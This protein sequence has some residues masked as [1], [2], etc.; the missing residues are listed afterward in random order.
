MGSDPWGGSEDL[1]SQAALRLREESHEVSASVAWW[2]QLH[3]KVLELQKREVHLFVRKPVQYNLPARIWRKI[4]RQIFAGGGKK[5]FDWLRRQKPDLVFISQGGTMD[6][7]EW[8]NFCAREKLPFAAVVHCNTESLWPHDDLGAEMLNAYRAAK[9]VFFVSRHNLKLLELQ[10]G[11]K[12]SNASVVWN[13]CK[14]ANIKPPAWPKESHLWRMACVARLDLAAKGQDLLFQVLGQ[15]Q[16]RERP[17]E[18][19][20]YGAGKC[21]RTL[22]KLAAGLQLQN[23]HFR[24]HVSDVKAIWEENHLLVLPS[25]YEGLPLVLVEAMWCARPSLVTDIGGNAELCVDGET[26]FVAAAPTVNLFDQALER[27]WN[28]RHEWQKMGNAARA[29]VEQLIPKDPIGDFCRQLTESAKHNH[30]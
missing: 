16:W 20:L 11:E 13:P 30:A 17:I 15:R 21:E 10:L 18:V 12:L 3:P 22:K 19:N 4:N 8:M 25:R 28:H 29:R 14:V 27:A 2:P 7:L 24:D 9:K 1:W 5:E 23:V 26:G 6:G